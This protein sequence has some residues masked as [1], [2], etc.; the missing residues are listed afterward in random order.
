[1]ETMTETDHLKW[2]KRT[3]FLNEE[4][5]QRSQEAFQTTLYN[6]SFIKVF[7]IYFHR[8]YWKAHSEGFIDVCDFIWNPLEGEYI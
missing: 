7:E 3:I 4:N 2:A 6:H 5:L 8:I 1:M